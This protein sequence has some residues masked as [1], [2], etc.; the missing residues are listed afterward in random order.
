MN[1]AQHSTEV[2]TDFALNVSKPLTAMSFTDSDSSDLLLAFEN[3]DFQFRSYSFNAD[4]NIWVQN[5]KGNGPVVDH[6]IH[7]IFITTS[8]EYMDQKSF[9]RG[10]GILLTSI[11]G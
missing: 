10:D 9:S 5:P 8:I 11:R 4:N 6:F 2:Y 7:P 3:D 1:K